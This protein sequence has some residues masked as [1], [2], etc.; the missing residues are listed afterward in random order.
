[1][2][3]SQHIFRQY[4]IRGIVG[5]DLDAGI[6]ESVGRA[7][8]SHLREATAKPNPQVALGCDN[9]LTSPELAAGLAAGLRA[10]GCGVVDVGTVPTPVLY[11]TEA[12]LETDAGVQITGS[13][14]PPEW[15]GIKLTVGRASLYGDSIQDL[16]RRIVDGD[17]ARGTGGYRQD[18]VLDRY[19]E[20]VAGRFRLARPVRV[21]ADCGNGTGSVVAVRLLEALGAEVTPLFCE[22]D[23]TFPNHH[24]D[25]TVDENLED[26]IRAVRSGGHD[27]GVAF[28]GDA[29]RI[30]AVDETG[31]IVRGDILLLLFGL[32]ILARR[33]GRQKLIFDVKCSQVLPEVY[34]QAG[35][36][37]IM[38]KTGHSLI[39]RKMK[40]TGAP[41]AGELSGHIMIGDG[42][43]GFD[44]ALYD[45]CRLI[46]LVARDDRPLSERVG[47]FPTYVST[48]EIRID[49]TEEQK[50]AVVAQAVSYFKTKHDVI[51]VDGARVLF[52]DGWALLR[53]SNTQ[54]VI[55]ARFEARTEGRLREIRGEVEDWLRGQG[56][57][58]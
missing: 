12:T 3:P 58:L 44:D 50:W 2:T 52:G 26:L 11:W 47:A 45:A 7:F 10:T 37:P 48:P 49:V 34:G 33:G 46:D 15:N 56:V 35:G 5:E 51:D 4:D 53:A 22:S 21:A 38:W 36:E 31:A 54:P 28:D 18:E 40:E 16:Y 1:M 43:L 23:G 30:G 6:A 42:Y 27:V 8:G 17:V 20:D 41:L 9:R 14:N 29:D 39:K 55:V 25:P 24:P 13:H 32:D 57:A 19:V